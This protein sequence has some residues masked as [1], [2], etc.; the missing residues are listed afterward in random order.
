MVTQ[1]IKPW[2]NC[3]MIKHKPANRDLITR[4]NFCMPTL[5][6]I[7]SN[8][9]ARNVLMSSMS[10]LRFMLK[11]SLSY[12]KQ[13]NATMFI[14]RIRL[15]F[16]PKTDKKKE[17]RNIIRIGIF[18]PSALMLI[19]DSNANSRNIWWQESTL[20]YQGTKILKLKERSSTFS[21]FLDQESNKLVSTSNR[22]QSFRSQSIFPA[23]RSW[24][25]TDDQIKRGKDIIEWGRR[26]LRPGR[27]RVWIQARRTCPDPRGRSRRSWL[28]R[29]PGSACSPRSWSRPPTRG[30]IRTSPPWEIQGDERD[31]VLRGRTRGRGGREWER[32]G[33][34]SRRSDRDVGRETM[35]DALKKR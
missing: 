34:W 22:T 12:R 7:Q 21:S 23:S 5:D 31:R 11:W 13:K 2:H 6:G 4:W 8:M 29:A 30:R 3:W 35:S 9:V 1:H 17:K 19:Q 18:T 27:G 33:K 20:W 10:S 25:R 16:N 24:R 26:S 15:I 32:R 14:T 28:G